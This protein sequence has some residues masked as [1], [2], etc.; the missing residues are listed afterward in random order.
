[1]VPGHVAGVDTRGLGGLFSDLQVIDGLDQHT[2]LLR[3]WSASGVACGGSAL[4]LL[5]QGWGV[6]PGFSGQ[7]R[8]EE[9]Q[10]GDQV[11]IGPEY[12]ADQRGPR[13]GG[14]VASV[15]SVSPRH[16]FAL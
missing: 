1:M 10:V 8:Q 16:W 2:A 7:G 6:G 13:V 12:P 9:G 3:G 4:G 11:H 5:V 14:V 15:H